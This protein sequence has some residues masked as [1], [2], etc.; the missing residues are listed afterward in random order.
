ML[1]DKTENV[2]F[3]LFPLHTVLSTLI[4]LVYSETVTMYHQAVSEI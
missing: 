3:S 4:G 1:A 2:N